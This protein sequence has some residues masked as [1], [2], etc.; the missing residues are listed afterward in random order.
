MKNIVGSH[1]VAIRNHNGYY[2]ITA[3]LDLFLHHAYIVQLTDKRYRQLQRVIVAGRSKIAP[4]TK[5]EG[6]LVE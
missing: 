3:L 2:K 5:L 4:V 6:Q 1:I